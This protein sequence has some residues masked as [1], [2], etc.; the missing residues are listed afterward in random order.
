MPAAGSISVALIDD[1]HAIRKGLGLLI[2]GTPGYRCTGAF[3]SVEEALRC[4]G[5]TTPDVLLLD[6]KLPGI[7]GSEGWHPYV[8]RNSPQSG[9]TVSQDRSRRKARP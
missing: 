7:P 2:D 8:S 5:G 9:A 1:E 6:I 4:L 3:G